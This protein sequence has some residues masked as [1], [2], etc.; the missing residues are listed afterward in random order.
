MRY[1]SYADVQQDLPCDAW[2]ALACLSMPRP[3]RLAE[4]RRVAP[5]LNYSR[6]MLGCGRPLAPS[7]D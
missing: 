7:K 4:H 3:A 6:T 1:A 2:H 5:L